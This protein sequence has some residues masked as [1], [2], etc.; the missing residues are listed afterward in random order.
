MRAHTAHWRECTP[1]AGCTRP[2]IL[3]VRMGGV[4]GVSDE[5][6]I[7]ELND[8]D[9]DST[10]VLYRRLTAIGILYVPNV[11][12]R[13]HAADTAKSLLRRSASHRAQ[14]LRRIFPLVMQQISSKKQ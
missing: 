2:K 6:S 5:E 14:G 9:I 3:Q 12:K 4:Q 7:K 1:E 8:L 13:R 11:E 10:L